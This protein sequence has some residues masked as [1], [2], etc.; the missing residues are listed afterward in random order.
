MDTYDK[1]GVISLPNLLAIYHIGD[2]QITKY[3]TL[4][5]L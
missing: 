4:P 3:Y 2:N 1:Y 5:G